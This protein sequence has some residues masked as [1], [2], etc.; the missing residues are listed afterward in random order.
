MIFGGYIKDPTASD[1]GWVRLAHRAS[2]ARLV[3]LLSSLIFD[4]LREAQLRTSPGIPPG[5]SH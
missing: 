1:R 2:C 3:G 4:S 5:P